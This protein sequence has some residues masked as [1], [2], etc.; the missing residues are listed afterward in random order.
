[1]NDEI[2]KIGSVYFIGIGGIGMSAIA[3]FF[4]SRGIKV[5]G[6]DRSE[7]GLIK[8]LVAEGMN[9]HFEESVEV[10]PKDVDIV[11]YTPAVSKNHQELV[12]YQQ[13]G[14]EV[15]KRSDVL[16]MITRS[17]FNICIAGTHGKTTTTTMIAHLLRDSGY[18]CNAFLGGISVNYETNF[19]SSGRNVCVVE[20]DEYDR[21]F[22]KLSPDIAVI[23]AMDPDHLDI[24]GTAEA[25]EEAFID[26]SKKVKPGGFLISKFGLKRRT[27]LSASKHLTYSLQNESADAYAENIRMKNGSYEFDV[28]IKDK[29]LK[30]VT[31]HMGGMHN[32][33]NAV[34]AITVAS[35]LEIENEKIKAAVESFKGVKRR[36]EYIIKNERIVFIDDY[37]H[38]PEELRALI[39]GA[40]SL[41]RQKKMHHYFSTPFV[42]EN[43]R[44]G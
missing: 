1:M 44:P 11:V 15:L 40:K 14:Y 36:F 22:L 25:M 6:Y 30:D 12:F 18:G 4:H 17:S 27:E 29:K 26:F 13:N 2:K 24:Y 9:I 28:V 39:N 42:H 10:I 19:F 3:R 7:S 21:S 33:E 43:K 8:E 37:A 41:F 23:S 20:A 35:S 32:V 38:H 5:S 34:A 31:L 16:E